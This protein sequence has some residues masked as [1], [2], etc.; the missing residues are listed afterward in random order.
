LWQVVLVR[1]QAREKG[2]RDNRPEGV[3]QLEI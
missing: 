1:W 2:Q 3:G